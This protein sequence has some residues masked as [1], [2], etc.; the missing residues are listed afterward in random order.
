MR[1][2]VIIP[3]WNGAA[4]IRECLDAVYAHTRDMLCEVICVDNASADD[5]AALISA[6]FPAAVLLCQ[7]V[8]LGFAG[9]VNAG[10]AASHGDV[11]VLLNQDCVVQPGWA[12]ALLGALDFRKDVGI[13]GGTLLDADGKVDHAGARIV[14]PLAMGEHLTEVNPVPTD[15][16]YVTG[17]I[18]TITRRT[19]T[20]VGLF[21][22]GFHPAYYEESDY[23]YR[24]RAMGI[25]TISTPVIL[26][27]HMRNSEAWGSDP[28][29]H[30]VNQQRSRYRFVAKHFETGELMAFFE[31][32]ES[33]I[34]TQPHYEQAIARTAAARHTQRRLSEGEIEI[35]RTQD[36]GVEASRA[37]QRVLL[38]GFATIERS[39][40]SRAHVL[41]RCDDAQLQALQAQTQSL[42]QRIFFRH[43]NDPS[44]ESTSS[45]LTRSVRRAANIA[46]G[47]ETVLQSQLNSLNAARNDALQ[48]RIQLVET[49]SAYDRD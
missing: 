39:A 46:S 35:R 47:R 23:C 44:V 6:H 2:S 4:V 26:G 49:I 43:P 36:L 32:E 48:R 17:A 20:S 42:M 7:P 45:R 38:D 8:N 31:A 25:H 33:A 28:L 21:D 19:L 9:G 27:K 24:A 22:E 16:D 14:R 10:L 15:V 30:V 13:A 40:F 37:R 41:A 18:F 34:E 11:C 1:I 12:E 29:Q 3:V 5:S